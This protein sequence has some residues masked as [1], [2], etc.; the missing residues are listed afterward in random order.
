MAGKPADAGGNR[1]HEIAIAPLDGD[2]RGVLEALV[3]EL[4]RHV[5]I[6]CR[7]VRQ[8]P[9]V[10]PLTV[11][12][13]TQL[14]ADRLLTELERHGAAGVPLV[15]VTGHDLGVPIFTFVFGRARLGG[16]AAVISLARLHQE[17]Y[18]LPPDPPLVARRAAAEILHE[19]G[20]VAGLAHCP[21]RSCLMS[22]AAGIEAADLRGLE[23]CADCSPRLPPGLAPRRRGVAAAEI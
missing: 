2:G 22:F 18:G 19:L 16:T 8:P 23:F 7:L 15:G 14:D 12:G 3:A 4:S 13:R 1:W 17:F 11:P 5:E 6:A 21:N 10:T 9:D 20:H